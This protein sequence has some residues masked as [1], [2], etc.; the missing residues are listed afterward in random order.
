MISENLLS[1][2]GAPGKG[3]EAYG[4]QLIGDLSQDVCMSELKRP[5]ASRMKR[6]GTL[7]EEMVNST[8]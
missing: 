6:V 1:T 3:L 8:A 4:G 5:V 7:G 2:D